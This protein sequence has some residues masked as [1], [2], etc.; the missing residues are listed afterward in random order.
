MKKMSEKTSAGPTTMQ[1]NGNVDAI[2]REPSKNAMIAYE[3]KKIGRAKK[4][5]ATTT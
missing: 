2:E 3:G 5:S 1:R 4:L